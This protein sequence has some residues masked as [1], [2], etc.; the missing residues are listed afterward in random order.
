MEAGQGLQEDHAEAD[1]LEGVEDAEPEEEGAGQEGADERVV[2]QDGDVE[3]DA[4]GGPE[5]LAPARGAEGDGEDGDEPGVRG[6]EAAEDEEDEGPDQNEEEEEEEDYDPGWGV[7]RTVV[8]G[9]CQEYLSP[10]RV[11]RG[12]H[13]LTSRETSSFDYRLQKENSSVR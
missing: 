5:H 3:G 2:G 9:S 7:L 12:W 6:R 8:K 11:W 10:P 4:G 13:W 1:A